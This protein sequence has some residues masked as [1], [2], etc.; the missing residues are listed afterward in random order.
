VRVPVL[1]IIGKK[2]LQVDWHAD[3]DPLQRAA[4]GRSDVS[5]LFPG[6]ANH[7][8]KHEPR[9]REELVQG[10][11]IARYNAPDASLDPDTVAAIVAWLTARA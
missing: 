6:D 4:A 11:A 8:L 3:A 7:V 10:E 2:D 1:I 5:F 9:P